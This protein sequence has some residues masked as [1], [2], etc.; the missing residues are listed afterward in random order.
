GALAAA[1]REYAYTLDAAKFTQFL[2]FKQW[3]ELKAYANERGV[4]IVGDVPIFVAFDSADVWASRELFELDEVGNPTVVAGVPPDYFSKTGQLWG[5]PLY[6]WDAM[7]KTGY[8]WWVARLKATLDFVDVVR[9]DHFRGFLAAWQVPA[10][11]KTAIVGEW[12]PGP[13]EDLFT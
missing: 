11:E 4:R 1:R 10:K 9:L 6:D 8:A 5:N 13:A 3:S 12:A 7:R 2:F